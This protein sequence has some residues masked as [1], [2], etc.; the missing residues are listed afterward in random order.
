MIGPGKYDDECTIVRESTNAQA[1]IVIVLGGKK[2]A[3]FS[4]QARGVHVLT[5]LP[6][7]LRNIASQIE[8]DE[9]RSKDYKSNWDR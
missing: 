2:G 8:D 1:A 4:C 7:I 5:G 9:L 3:G 6:G